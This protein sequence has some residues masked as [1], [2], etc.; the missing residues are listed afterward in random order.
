MRRT[1]IHVDSV[2]VNVPAGTPLDAARLRT[3][4]VREISRLPATPKAWATG[5]R[6]V[7]VA[8]VDAQRSAGSEGVARAVASALSPDVRSRRRTP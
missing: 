2:V 7:P 3:D 1:S 8:H 4:L 5:E 6:R